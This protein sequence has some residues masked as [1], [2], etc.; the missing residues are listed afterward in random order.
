MRRDSRRTRGY[1]LSSAAGLFIVML[2][3]CTSADPAVSA[4]TNAT[5][6]AAA[7]LEDFAG[8]A[9]EQGAPAV[10]LHVRDGE[11]ETAKAFGVRDL[12]SGR[13]AEVTDRLWISGAG[14]SMLAVSVMKLVEED[15]ITLDDP[16]ADILP[17]FSTIFP[18]WSRTTVRE[19]LG[20]RTGL[21]DYVPPLLASMP[22][23]KL[24]TTVL[25][26]EERLRLAASV[27]ADP[28][29]VLA[30]TWSATDWEVLAWLVERLRG[31]SLAEVLRA[32]VFEPAGMTNSLLPGPGLPPEPM[33]HAYVQTGDTRIDFTRIDAITG[34]GDAGIVSSVIDI[35]RFLAAL[36]TGRLVRADTW[37]H[38]AGSNPYDLGVETAENICPGTKHVLASGGGGPYAVH[39]ATT[40]DGRQQVSV[41]MVLPPAPLD[42][43]NIPPLVRQMEGALRA[44]AAELCS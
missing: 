10:I 24:Q 41:A 32:D 29:T 25:T 16:V 17:E 30:A 12:E 5:V 11:Q 39:S 36:T 19:L 38:M 20:S 18:G 34:S 14:T 15:R 28:K 31:K 42:S 35:N 23:E 43:T 1:W 33:L 3:G 13:A 37:Q 7:Q 2:A 27:G 44:T 9:A 40:T 22:P 26:F 6:R 8:R 4:A 21:P